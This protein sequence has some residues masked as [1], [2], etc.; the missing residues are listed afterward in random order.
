MAAFKDLARGAILFY[1]WYEDLLSDLE[2]T[3]KLVGSP[4][5]KRVTKEERGIEKEEENKSNFVYH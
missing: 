1:H 3:L 5:L 4:D 2:S